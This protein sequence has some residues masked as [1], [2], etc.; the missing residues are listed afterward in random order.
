MKKISTLFKKDPNDLG[1]VLNELNPENEWV[2]NGE[3]IATR[4][5]DGIASA[6]IS[7]EPYKRF[8][9]KKGKT[10]PEGAIPCQEPDEKSGHHPHWLKCDRNKP[11]DKYFFEAFDALEDKQDGTYELCGETISTERF[12]QNFNVEKVIGH[13]FIKHG[14]EILELPGL[15]YEAIKEFLEKTENDIEGIVFHH[16][17]DGRMCKI[18]KKDFGIVRGRVK[19]MIILFPSE[20]FSPKEVDSSFASEFEAAKLSGFKVFLFDHDE[21]VKTG[22]FKTNLRGV[23]EHEP[24]K[25]IIL[26][27]WMLNSLQYNGLYE[28][29]TSLGYN[30]INGIKQYLNC[31]HIPESF[32]N[33][34]DYTSKTW[35]TNNSY[36]KDEVEWENVQWQSIRDYFET[37]VIIKDYVKSE[38]GNPD[39]FI[40]PKTLSESEFG[41][42]VKQF[43][44]ARGKLFNEGIVF[45]EVV[46][47]KKY[48]TK[49]GTTTNEWRIFCLNHDFLYHELNVES[50]KK[51][52]N[53]PWHNVV[54][55]HEMAK[56]ID[57]NFFTIDVAEKE[58]GSWMILEIGDGQVSG[59]PIKGM[60]L[61]F[62]AE[63][64]SQLK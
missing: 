2:I 57:S 51:L 7:G 40:L 12:S 39:L 48:E 34:K 41:L 31:H 28:H 3:A 6:I 10:V 60:P 53:A 29:L 45:K 55:W 4:K 42:K 58:D 18:R 27:S 54:E 15:T 32:A 63:L 26:R 47:L 14:S 13:K 17:T 20:P 19:E 1:K 22:T 36:N 37:D 59:L 21:F 35:W 50:D 46:S 30:L 52:P 11:E 44:E 62:Y 61:A 33:I 5:F 24:N 25:Q 56:T 49:N 38:K 8:D 9:V 23:L 16:K 43:V 64:K